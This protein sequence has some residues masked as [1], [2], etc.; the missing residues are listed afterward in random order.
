MSRKVR[1]IIFILLLLVGASVLFYPTF[2]NLWNERLQARTIGTYEEAAAQL[3]DEQKSKLL[4]EARE[5]NA[6]H[7]RNDIV[8]AFDENNEYVLTHPYDKLLEID[9]SGVMCY[10]EIPKINSKLAVYH[11][12]SAEVLEKGVGHLQGTSLPVGGESTHAVL[13][14]HRGLP[15]AKLFTDLDSVA[16]GDQFY[17]HVLDEHLAYE[18][19]AINTVLPE[20]VELLDIEP[21]KDLVTLITCTPY[22]V[23]TH[24]LLVRGH[25]VPY[26]PPEEPTKTLWEKMSELKFAILTLLAGLL[27]LGIGLAIYRSKKRKKKEND[28]DDLQEK[29]NTYLD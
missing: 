25:R 16:V 11:G 10:L 6:Q 22:G 23:N 29:Q 5:F 4:E 15:S 3:T 2:S 27:A 7:L 17:I 19:D 24:R 28:Q 9:G 12:I 20:E 21:G 1:I 18:V 8:D 26:V 13:S 14:A